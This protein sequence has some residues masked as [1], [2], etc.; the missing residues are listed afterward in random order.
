MASKR[1]VFSLFAAI[2]LSFLWLSAVEAQIMFLGRG[3]HSQPLMLITASSFAT[4][5]AVGWWGGGGGT[6]GRQWQ[7]VQYVRRPV[8][9]QYLK[10]STVSL[11]MYVYTD[12]LML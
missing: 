10:R 12:V 1:G 6:L 8:H 4:E 3:M 9:L 2:S 5:W 7:A 11:N